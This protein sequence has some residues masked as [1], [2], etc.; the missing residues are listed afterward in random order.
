[1]LSQHM[2]TTVADAPP[3]VRRRAA[4]AGSPWHGAGA[5]A[6]ALLKLVYRRR[7]AVEYTSMLWLAAG[8]TAS[9]VLADV[10]ATCVGGTITS[11]HMFAL[12]L[13]L[14]LILV[15]NSGRVRRTAI[16]LRTLPLAA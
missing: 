9:A 10:S 15:N 4:L 5:G 6:G 12:A 7:C 8:Q 14:T 11:G 1:M 13:I 3:G 2:K 16:H